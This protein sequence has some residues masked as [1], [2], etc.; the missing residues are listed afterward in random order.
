MVQARSKRRLYFL[1]F[2]LP[3]LFLYALFF[4]YPFGRG[5]AI[6]FTNWDGLTP[7]SPISMPKAEFESSILGKVGSDA[8][9][10][11]LLSVYSLDESDGAY[12]RLS[13]RGSTRNR[14]ERI[15]ARAGYQPENYRAVGFRNYAD[16]FTG[17][18]DAR[19]YPRS[20]T[21]TNY[22]ETS[23]LP[24]EI[25]RAEADRLLLPKLDTAE[26]SVLGSFYTL[27]GDSYRLK[28]AADEFA[29]E[30]RIWGLPEVDSLGL[31][32]STAVDGLVGALQD[33]GLAGDKAAAEAALA[34]FLGAA[35]FSDGSRKAAAEA[36]EGIYGLGEIKH[37]LATKWVE[38]KTDLGVIGFTIFFAVLAVLLSNLLAFLIALALDTRIRTRNVLRSV[39]FLPNVLS[40]IVVALIWSIV[41]SRL[42][43]YVT[44]IALWMGDPDKAPWLVVTVAVWQMAGYYMIIYLA[45]LQNIPTDVVEAAKI[46]GARGLQVLRRITLPLLLPAITVCLFLSTANALK[47]FDLVYA[48]VGPSGYALGT[49][50]FVMDIYFDAFANKLVGL[51]T[52]KATILFLVILTITGLQLFFMKRKEVQA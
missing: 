45:G 10:A 22:K 24:K 8:D 51:A 1:A 13:I 33:S 27:E 35:K 12:H 34:A 7:K 16:I 3:A 37:I 38:K 49:V 21:K 36:A 4:I 40:M 11:Y 32:D 41:F 26:R 48:L 6:S 14:V 23:E 42:L 25:A 5:L 18:V 47:C 15:V 44:G 29:M 43:P 28:P 31:V 39:F 30:D 2:V 9:R 19:F 20:Y 17:K 52:A 46:D 50:P